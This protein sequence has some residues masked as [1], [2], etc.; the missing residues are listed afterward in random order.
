MNG[1]R[2]Q[3]II[4]VTRMRISV[5]SG[6]SSGVELQLHRVLDIGEERGHRLTLA[7]DGRLI[8]LLGRVL[9]SVAFQ[10]AECAAAS[11]APSGP[12]QI[13]SESFAGRIVPPQFGQRVAS[14]TAWSPQNF[15][16][17]GFSLP[18]FEHRIS[19]PEGANWIAFLYQ[20]V[21]PTLP[22]RQ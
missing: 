15:L 7:V 11:A 20:P 12:P 8:G 14:A 9:I 2:S 18:Q 22:A 21:W 1:K 6:S 10:G 4:K 19:L 17:A 5:P 3:A 13:T 16:P